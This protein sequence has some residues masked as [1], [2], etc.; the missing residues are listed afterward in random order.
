MGVKELIWK[1]FFLGKSLVSTGIFTPYAFNGQRG[2]C[3]ETFTK[4]KKKRS[5]DTSM[6][7]RE[8]EK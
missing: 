3:N 1:E 8:I 5:I 4:G 6:G 2:Y 7:R